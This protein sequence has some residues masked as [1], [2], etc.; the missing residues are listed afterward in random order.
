MGIPDGH[1]QAMGIRDQG[2]GSLVGTRHSVPIVTL[3]QHAYIF[4][5]TFFLKMQNLTTCQDSTDGVGSTVLEGTRFYNCTVTSRE[6]GDADA[7]SVAPNHT[8]PFSL[9]REQ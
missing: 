3:S 1:G 4:R 2:S 6:E 5:Y 9:T 7:F 8:S